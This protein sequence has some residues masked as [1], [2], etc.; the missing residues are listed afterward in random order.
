MEQILATSIVSSMYPTLP[1]SLGR[2]SPFL[3][4]QNALIFNGIGCWVDAFYL[5]LCWHVS[6]TAFVV[7]YLS[8]VVY[9]FDLS[10]VKVVLNPQTIR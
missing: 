7:G 3:V 4:K 10:L 6:D 1:L 5:N 8:I 2:G 9:Y